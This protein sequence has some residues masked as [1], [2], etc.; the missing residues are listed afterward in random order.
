MKPCHL[1]KKVDK[2]LL[3]SNTQQV[4]LV[5]G[6]PGIL[7][8]LEHLLN[9]TFIDKVSQLW[10]DC[11]HSE[12]NE[13]SEYQAILCVKNAWEDLDIDVIKSNF[14][15]VC[16]KYAQSS[17]IGTEHASTADVLSGILT[18][19]IDVLPG[20]TSMLE[21]DQ[22]SQN[23]D[24]MLGNV[25]S[26]LN[27][28]ALVTQPGSQDVTGNMPSS[29][30]MEH[31]SYVKGMTEMSADRQNIRVCP[32]NE[33]NYD[34][35]THSFEEEDDYINE[36]CNDYTDFA[37]EISPDVVT[38]STSKQSS[39]NVD[40]KL[41]AIALVEATSVKTAAKRYDVRAS[42][43]RSWRRKKDQLLQLPGSKKRDRQSGSGY[44]LTLDAKLYEWVL[45]QQADGVSV[46]R[47]MA[48]EKAIELSKE[49]EQCAIK[50]F[51]GSWS[52]LSRFQQRYDVTLSNVRH[53]VARIP[54]AGSQSLVMFQNFVANR[55]QNMNFNLSQIAM[56]EELKFDLDLTS[57][58]I[59]LVE[60][61]MTPEA[62][63]PGQKITFT[64]LLT[65]L[66]DGSK[67]KPMIMFQKSGKDG[68]RHDYPK[69]V[70]VSS[71]YEAKV[72]EEAVLL[73]IRKVGFYNNN[74]DLKHILFPK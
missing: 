20:S 19:D 11:S 30:Q 73:W 38:P 24:A 46:T 10:K 74:W 41:E 50:K 55:C 70:V 26:D 43:L 18:D 31:A 64:V 12:D 69:G 35:E 51:S 62:D 15:E 65:C 27:I 37:V 6:L 29:H 33:L 59:D 53:V 68:S 28:A 34:D 49:D 13:Q 40:F 7:P 63:S 1:G 45:S 67:L 22:T 36:N 25:L 8:A 42:L 66:A 21:Q 17:E 48:R 4:F 61:T 57:G 58:S 14:S 52:W 2:A 71:S 44:F 60:N 9:V 56:M 23:D 3:E 16:I 47:K 5:E 72:D 32:Q 39:Y 54:D